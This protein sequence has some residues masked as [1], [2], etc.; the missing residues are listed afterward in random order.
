[1]TAVL[2]AGTGLAYYWGYRDVDRRHS[3][4][5]SEY[6]DCLWGIA[7]Y[8]VPLTRSFYEEVDQHV[9]GVGRN[10]LC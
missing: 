8:S 9:T 4:D 7:I 10:V 2:L 1:M 3:G 6:G 5:N